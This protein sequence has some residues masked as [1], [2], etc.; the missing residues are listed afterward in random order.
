MNY[1]A[2]RNAYESWRIAIAAQREIAIRKGLIA[3]SNHTEEVW[4]AEG[5]LGVQLLDAVCLGGRG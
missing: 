1:D 3:P 2:D 5:F 4:A